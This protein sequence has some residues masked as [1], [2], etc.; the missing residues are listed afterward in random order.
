MRNYAFVALGPLRRFFTAP[1][2]KDASNVRK[3][4]IHTWMDGGN[5][6]GVSTVLEKSPV[7]PIILFQ[8]K[9]NL[10]KMDLNEKLPIW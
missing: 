2:K 7:D 3:I 5:V 1:V 9:V 4:V 8:P 10:G 6:S